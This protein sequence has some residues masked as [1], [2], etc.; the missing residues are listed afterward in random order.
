MNIPTLDDFLD[1]CHVVSLPLR[2]RFRG[3]REREAVIFEGPAGWGEFS[4]FLEYDATE[5]L[6]WLKC[7]LEMA[8]VGSPPPVRDKVEVNATVPAVAPWQI[9][10]VL[11]RFPGC[12]T[13]KVKVAE[14][15]GTL[16]DDQARIDAIRA[17]LPGAIIRVDANGGW[18]VDEALKAAEKLGP[19]DYMEQP[20]AT[21]DELAELRQKLVARNL[22]VKVAADESI[23]K[24]TDPFAVAR[25]GAADVAVVKAA[26]LGGPRAVLEVAE[27]M[28]ATGLDI[29]V[30]SALDTGVG[31]NAGLAAAAALPDRS[32][33]GGL[34]TQRLFVADITAQRPLIDGYLSTTP[35]APEESRLTEFAATGDRKDF[36]MTRIRQTWK[37]L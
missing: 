17:F 36:W 22:H 10:E 9:D 5:S 11:A 26:P 21:V 35:L 16:N 24:A 2:V 30:S 14:K 3:V 18:S 34:A 27:F 37:L 28:R 31:M 1:R 15:G 29:T 12:R 20:C 33:P 32:V 19:L 13:I 6:P 23:R 8:F 25:K 4:P 7:G